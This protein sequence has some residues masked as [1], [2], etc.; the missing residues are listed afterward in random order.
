MW[1]C[2]KLLNSCE[3]PFWQKV[4]EWLLKL[5]I[6]HQTGPVAFFIM[7]HEI[8]ASTEVN[9][10]AVITQLE[11]LRLKDVDWKNVSQVGFAAQTSISRTAVPSQ[12]M[13]FI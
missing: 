13:Q 6:E 4:Q 9:L 10:S 11:K 5:D 12:V 2:E 3:I 7:M 8:M 1:S